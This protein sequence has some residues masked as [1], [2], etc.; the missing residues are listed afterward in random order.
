[1][2]DLEIEIEMNGR[3]VG[4]RS[5]MNCLPELRRHGAR[6]ADKALCQLRLSKTQN[7]REVR[8]KRLELKN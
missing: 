7:R 3:R 8:K 6:P 5:G 1:M 4:F 2:R